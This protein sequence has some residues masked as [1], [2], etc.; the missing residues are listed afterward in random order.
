M[1]RNDYER[2]EKAIRYL[3]SNWQRQPKLEEVAKASGSSPFHFQRLFRRWAGVS[4]KRFLQYL[5]AEYAK[6]RLRES[7]SVLDAAYDSGLTGP[8]RLHDLFVS[9]EAMTPGEYKAQGA[10]LA[11]GWGAHDTPFGKALVAVTR[12]GVCGLVFF[13]G[14][15]ESKA[16]RE[17]K[18]KWPRSRFFKEREKTGEIVKS[19][20]R[21]SPSGEVRVLLKGTP[22]QVKVWEALLRIPPGFMAAYK[23]VAEEIGR[24]SASRAVGTAVGQNNIAYLIPCHRVIRETGIVGDYRWGKTRKKAILAWDASRI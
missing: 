22:F 14:G 13:N 18:Q 24:P 23:D 20:F 21:R 11:I 3:E 5:T 7:E 1:K 19:V 17:L 2:V 4:P 15:G 10:G 12:R 16:L 8:G 6:K 9:V